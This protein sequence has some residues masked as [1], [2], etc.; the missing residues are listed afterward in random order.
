MFRKLGVILPMI[1]VVILSSGCS[2]G[3]VATGE[4]D[5]SLVAFPGSSNDPTNGQ[6]QSGSGGGVTIEV[7]WKGDRSGSLVFYIAMN[8]HS[9]DLDGYD[10]GKLAMLR[11]YEGKEYKPVSW[12][13]RPGGHHRQGTL[14]FSSPDSLIQGKAKRLEL[15]IRDVADIPEWSFIWEFGG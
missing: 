13:S 10:L 3:F 8:T 6:V 2:S 12:E 7:E 11:D 9:V 15:I 5:V 1:M 14:T 4:E